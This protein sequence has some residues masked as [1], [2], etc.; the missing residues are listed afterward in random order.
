MH[1]L[2]FDKRTLLVQPDRAC[3]DDVPPFL[4]VFVLCCF[5][6]VPGERTPKRDR[7]Q[8]NIVA[9]RKNVEAS[10]CSRRFRMRYHSDLKQT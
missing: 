7:A 4:I 5:C 10:R 9:Q 6:G 3:R 8:K 2:R 1:S